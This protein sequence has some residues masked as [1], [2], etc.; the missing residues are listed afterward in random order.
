MIKP[1]I[2][3]VVSALRIDCRH[4]ILFFLKVHVS[5]RGQ[6][7]ACSGKHELYED[8]PHSSYADYCGFKYGQMATPTVTSIDPVMVSSN[9]V[10]TLSGSGFSEIPSENYVF[11]GAIECVVT[12]SSQS[13]IECTLGTGFGGSKPLYLRVLYSGVAETNALSVTFALTVTGVSPSEGSQAGGTEVTITGA[14]FYHVPSNNSDG[15]S[16]PASEAVSASLSNVTE[17]SSGWRNEVLLGG[18]PCTVINSTATSLTIITPEEPSPSSPA[19][20]LEVSI[21]CPDNLMI[22]SDATLQDAFSYNSSLTST[23]LSITPTSG[24]VQGGETVVISGTGFSRSSEVFVSAITV[25]NI[26]TCLCS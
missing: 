1:G 7:A 2:M 26:M 15:G 9:E 19:Y 8:I 23:V 12:S 14:G 6:L 16:L 18:V 25:L 22:S 17:C 11:F 3:S 4:H 21:V 20:D 13:R 10:I 5:I 24:T